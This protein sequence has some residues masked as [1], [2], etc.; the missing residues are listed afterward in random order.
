MEKLFFSC[1]KFLKKNKVLFFVFAIFLFELILRFCQIGERGSLGLD[2]VDNAWAAKN[3]IV[4]H[5]FPLV[6]MV[7]KENSGIYIGPAYYYLASVFYWLTNLNPI[8]SPLFAGVTSIF[9]FWALFYFVKKLT[10]VG[11]AVIAVTINTFA[12][13][14]ISF[15]RIQWPVDFIPAVS[16][17]IFYLL[18]RVVTG[19]SKKLIWLALA[20]G[21]AFNIH[22]TAIFFP[23]IILLSLPIFPRNKETIKYLLMSVLLFVLCLMPNIIYELT[24]K[25]HGT[26]LSEYFRDNYHGFHLRRVIQ[27]TRDGLIQFNHYLGWNQG[28]YLKFFALPVFFIL[29]LYKSVKRTKLVFSYLVLLWFVVPWFIFA[30]YSGEISDYYFSINRFIVVMILSYFVYRVWSVKSLIVK[31]VVVLVLFIFCVH[32]LMIF[33]PFKN[34]GIVKEEIKVS[35]II[36]NG[37]KI[38]WKQGSPDSYIYYYLMRQKGINVY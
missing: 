11:V 35:K 13:S 28:E 10:N 34:D 27:L 9:T 22:F 30:L 7:A 16:L 15:D 21:F 18:Y 1:L 29:Y 36:D 33:L 20:T 25:S 2:Q 3:I 23:I 12:Y 32:N 17:I 26:A 14:A 38:K 31:V 37:G 6:G 5:N 24:Q 19:D 4:D 8:A